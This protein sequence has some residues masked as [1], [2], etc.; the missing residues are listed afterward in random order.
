MRNGQPETAYPKIRGSLSQNLSELSDSQI[1]AVFKRQNIDAESLE[2]FFDDLGKIASSVGT[3]VVKAAPTVLPIAGQVVGTAFGG[4]L[5]AALGGQLGSIAGGAIGAA[6]GQ[7][8]AAGGA[9][10]GPLG[11]VASLL[12]GSPAAGQLLQTITRPETMQALMSMFMGPMGKPNIPVGPAQTPVPVGAF[13]NLLGVLTNQA[14]AEYNASVSAANGRPPAYMTDYAGE[15]K[16]DP[17]VAEDR[18]QA[19]LELLQNVDEAQESAEASY[20]NYESYESEMEAIER[21]YDEMEMLEMIEGA[22]EY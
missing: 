20:E 21:E 4:P 19:L 14:A 13:S 22:E 11:A 7:R 5:G 8:P 15:A 18:A 3:A 9:A 6:T 1:E 10:P 17:A 2:G 12:G 16:G